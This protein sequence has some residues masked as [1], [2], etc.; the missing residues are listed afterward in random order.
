MKRMI[1]LCAALLLLIAAPT[2]ADES[3][4]DPERLAVAREMG[5][6]GTR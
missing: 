2:R 3:A 1:G 4:F 5:A 6:G